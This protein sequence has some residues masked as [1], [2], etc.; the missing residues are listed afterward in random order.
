MP[1]GLVCIFARDSPARILIGPYICRLTVCKSQGMMG[2][3]TQTRGKIP[4]AGTDLE[5]PVI[6]Q[7]PMSNV[8]HS[9]FGRAHGISRFRCAKQFYHQVIIFHASVIN[10]STQI[11]YA[12]HQAG[13]EGSSLPT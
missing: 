1:I 4:A 10:L 5:K 6:F 13:I 12:P 7:R 9:K 11:S 3:R 8:Q 2:I